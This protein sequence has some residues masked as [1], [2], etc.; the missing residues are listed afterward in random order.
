MV[1][2]SSRSLGRHIH[3]NVHVEVVFGHVQAVRTYVPA[4]LQDKKGTQFLHFIF[5]YVCIVQIADA[6]EIVRLLLLVLSMP[7]YK[8]TCFSKANTEHECACAIIWPSSTSMS[9]E[10]I[11]PSSTSKKCDGFLTKLLCREG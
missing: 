10:G 4:T 8:L 9:H 1:P 6:L 5:L 7:L 2:L 11:R 3:Q